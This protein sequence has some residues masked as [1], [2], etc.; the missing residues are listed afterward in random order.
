MKAPH[1]TAFVLT[2]I[3]LSFQSIAA[4]TLE[5]DYQFQGN[6]NSSVADAPSLTNSVGSDPN[7]F[8]AVEDGA[9]VNA[10]TGASVFVVN[11]LADTEDASLGDGVCAD[12]AGKCTLRA[13]VDESNTTVARDAIIFSVP[14]PSVINLTLGEL[15]INYSVDIVGPGARLLTVQRSP[16]KKVSDSV[17]STLGVGSLRIYAT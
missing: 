14:Q 5:A 8:V 2:A 3:V 9:R 17:F 7:S 10:Q 11:D 12:V 1:F 15:A 6:L 16:S 13:A 4:Q